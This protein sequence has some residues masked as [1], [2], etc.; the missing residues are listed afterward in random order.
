MCNRRWEIF[1][2]FVILIFLIPK[3]RGGDPE[4]AFR[5]PA[6]DRDNAVLVS[7]E[8]AVDSLGNYVPASFIDA[9]KNLILSMAKTKDIA[10]IICRHGPD[11]D[12]L[13]RYYQ[14]RFVGGDVFSN[15]YGK[16][17]VADLEGYEHIF[18]SLFPDV[19]GDSAKVFA[20]STFIAGYSEYVSSIDFLSRNWKSI[21]AMNPDILSIHF[22]I[23]GNP[24]FSVYSPESLQS[25]GSGLM[26]LLFDG[27]TLLYYTHVIPVNYELD[28]RSQ[29]SI[30][31]RYFK[32]TIH[33][34]LPAI[35]T[36]S[37]CSYDVTMILKQ[38]CLVN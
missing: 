2:F 9:V 34:M 18:D 37:N 23:D 12:T 33:V 32:T 7:V 38:P 26:S 19:S 20:D 17:S 30:Y 5:P 21:I 10:P 11:T 27:F 25:T 35:L 1:C 29:P 4:A 31:F 24:I 8:E 13:Y 16:W 36:G 14:K 3:C 15:C 28:I 6:L 22:D